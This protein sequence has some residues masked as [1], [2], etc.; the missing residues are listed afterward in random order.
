MG[1]RIS[2]AAWQLAAIEQTEGYVSPLSIELMVKHVRDLYETAG[3]SIQTNDAL[4]QRINIARQQAH[5]RS[6]AKLIKNL[7]DNV[8]N[9]DGRKYIAALIT[10]HYRLTDVRV[11]H[12]LDYFPDAPAPLNDNRGAAGAERLA[13]EPPDSLEETEATATKALFSASTFEV[14]GL[15]VRRY[16]SPTSKNRSEKMLNRWSRL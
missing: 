9:D 16:A 1:E 5:L 8:Y 2:R 13:T 10:E 6:A 12:R 3:L 15:G 11:D 14:V 4:D 7:A